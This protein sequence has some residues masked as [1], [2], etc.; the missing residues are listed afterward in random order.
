[1]RRALTLF[2]MLAALAPARAALAQHRVHVHEVRVGSHG[3]YDRVVVELDGATDVAWERGAQNA[4]SF[5]VDADLGQ[6]SRVV[7]TGLAR[8]GDVTLTAMRVGTRLSL[9]PRDRRVRAYV[10]AK[11]TRL[12][13]DVAPP[14]AEPFATPKGVTALTPASSVAPVM[15][16]GAEAGGTAGAEAEPEPEKGPPAEEVGPIG[17][18]DEPS[19]APQAEAPSEPEPDA[20]AEAPAKAE[21]NA[22]AESPPAES[23]EPNAA[24]AEPAP[25]P[26]PAPEPQAAQPPTP[27]PAPAAPPE[28][29]P[30]FP[31][32]LALGTAAFI[33]VLGAAWYFRGRLL[34]RTPKRPKLPRSPV[35]DLTPMG[36]DS[37]S[38]AEL[39]GAA[40]A[41]AVLE[42][43]LDEEVR[44]R[45]AL[46][47]R[48]A[49]AGEE[50][51]VL[52]DRLH[53]VERRRDEAR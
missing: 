37:F 9:E 18:P 4:E 53:R 19:P 22:S 5:Y 41:T 17:P 50:L 48:L 11:P 34:E 29:A 25:A 42:Q 36:V 7:H 33:A 20:Q 51:K 35:A 31:W 14:G 52:R 45:V 10:L 6:R 27:P 40:D 43:R 38:P 13:I 12:V 49:Q 23:G 44:A 8:V 21:P 3:D 32:S 46:E 28:P 1:M 39:R 26:E 24:A 30:G 2:A 47:E 15:E 16:A